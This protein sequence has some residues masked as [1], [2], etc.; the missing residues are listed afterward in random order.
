[1]SSSAPNLPAGFGYF[2][3]VIPDIQISLRYAT[4]ENL[5]GTVID[6]YLSN[7]V[8]II[9]EAAGL[10]LKQVQSAAQQQSYE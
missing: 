3:Q 6:G 9:N 5:T 2:H 8:A 4:E 10:A 7:N 1:M